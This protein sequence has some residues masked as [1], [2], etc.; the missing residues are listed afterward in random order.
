MSQTTSGQSFSRPPQHTVA[1]VLGGLGLFILGA[2]VGT[3]SLH[4]W[5]AAHD[6]RRTVQ[7][8][9]YIQDWQLNCPPAKE[10]SDGCSVKQLILQQGS[11]SPLAQIEVDRGVNADLIKFVVPLGVL[12]GPGLAFATDGTRP[13]QVAYT[14][15]DFSGCIAMA[16]LTAAQRDQMEHGTGGR[17]IILGRNGKAAAVPYSLKG[18]ADAMRERD[19]DWH[20][21]AGHWF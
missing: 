17:I 1:M 10:T 18:F 11:N 7:T 5:M 3:V 15:C 13:V 12:V 6:F 8:A 19:S 14:T 21:R 20:K 9:E 16:P 2:V 4:F